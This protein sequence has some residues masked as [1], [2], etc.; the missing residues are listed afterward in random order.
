MDAEERV[1]LARYPTRRTAFH[2]YFAWGEFVIS[3]PGSSPVNGSSFPQNACEVA[4]ENTIPR[5]L[6]GLSVAA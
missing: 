3:R 2:E 4:N 5:L 6:N 1:L